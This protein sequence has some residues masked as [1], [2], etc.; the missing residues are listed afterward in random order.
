MY[1]PYWYDK[2]LIENILKTLSKFYGIGVTIPL[3]KLLCKLSNEKILSEQNIADSLNAFKR[4]LDRNIDTAIFDEDGFEQ[5]STIFSTRK[6]QILFNQKV[7]VIFKYLQE[8]NLITGFGQNIDEYIALA[9]YGKLHEVG[10]I[11]ITSKGINYLLEE[12]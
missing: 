9:M 10:P 2:E 3:S 1:K 7:F 4:M 5:L 8:E 12:D 6:E 11:S